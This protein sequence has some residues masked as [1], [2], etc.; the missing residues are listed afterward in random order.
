MARERSTWSG[1]RRHLETEEKV[2]AARFDAKLRK[3]S[4]IIAAPIKDKPGKH[5]AVA[6]NRRGE[7]LFAWTEGMGWNRGGTLTWQIFAADG[8]PVGAIGHVRGVPVWSL[9]AVFT[10]PDGGFTIIY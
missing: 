8:K 10:R 9:V 4:D 2:Y 6:A 3:R 7:I 1:M 5:P